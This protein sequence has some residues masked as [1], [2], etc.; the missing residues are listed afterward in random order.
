[1][2]LRGLKQFRSVRGGKAREYVDISRLANDAMDEIGQILRTPK[3]LRS[4]NKIPLPV[5]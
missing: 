2:R 5:E 3:W 4:R 1:M